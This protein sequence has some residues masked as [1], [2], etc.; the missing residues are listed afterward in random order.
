MRL[1]STP[2][3]VVPTQCQVGEGPLWHA[4][5]KT[6]FFLD[7]PA[8]EVHAYTPEDGEHRVVSRGRPTGG[9][10]IQEDGNLLLL[11][12]GAVSILTPDGKQPQVREGIG[13]PGARFNDACADPEGRV[14]A[15]T[16]GDNGKLLRFDLDG[17]V[18]EMCSGVGCTNGMGF[19]LDL[20]EMYYTDSVPRQIYKFDYD[21]GSGALSNRRVF[22]QLSPADGLPDGM[23]IDAQGCL[24]S[25]V[26]FGA[27][28]KR[29]T[30]DGRLEREIHFPVRQTSSLAFAGDDLSDIYVTSA[31]VKGASKLMPPD[32]DPEAPRGGGLYGL[33]VEGVRGRL[34]FRSRVRF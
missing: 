15:G 11:Q 22:A 19:T 25:A 21:R 23:A 24:W 2:Q 7:V 10:V 12:D 17:R 31:G 6:L 9:M 29:F 13:D 26:W 18:T 4:E 33:R 27:R 32:M 16:V 34:P 30:P 14:Y 5:T 28:L 8:G 1:T 3:L 20:K